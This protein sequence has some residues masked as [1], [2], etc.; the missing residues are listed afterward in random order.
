MDLRIRSLTIPP[1]SQR[2]WMKLAGIVENVMLTQSKPLSLINQTR[3]GDIVKQVMDPDFEVV[4][5]W[6]SF[7]LLAIIGTTA[8]IFKCEIH[9]LE[10]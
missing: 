10:T 8:D 7:H 1:I 4:D 6:Q 2:I 9:R 5:C 3:I